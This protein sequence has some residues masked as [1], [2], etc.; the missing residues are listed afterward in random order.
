M[1]VAGRLVFVNDAAGDHLIDD[2]HRALVSSLRRRL[3]VRV[4]GTDDLFYAGT[5]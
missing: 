4:D 3:V 2:W 5:Q 1:F